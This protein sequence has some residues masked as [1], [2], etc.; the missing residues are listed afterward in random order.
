MSLTVKF[1]LGNNIRTKVNEKSFVMGVCNSINISVEDLCRQ[2]LLNFCADMYKRAEAAKNEAIELA[3]KEQANVGTVT[4]EVAK[5]ARAPSSTGSVSVEQP[6]E[7]RS[8]QT[9]G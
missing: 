7:V 8:D 2:L 3:K 1:K 5:D 9:V 6:S 4:D